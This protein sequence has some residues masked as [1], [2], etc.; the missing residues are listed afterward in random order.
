MPH[1]KKHRRSRKIT[2]KVSPT[3]EK[4]KDLQRDVNN[5]KVQINALTLNIL[6][7]GEEIA[8]K[9][10]QDILLEK[11]IDIIE[12]PKQIINVNTL[13][14]AKGETTIPIDYD[15]E[16]GKKVWS[17]ALSK[18]ESIYTWFSLNGKVN[19]FRIFYYIDVELDKSENSILGNVNLEVRITDSIRNVIKIP[20]LFDVTNQKYQMYSSKV[21][22]IV[23]DVVYVNVSRNSD[24]YN[25]KIYV[26]LI[27]LTS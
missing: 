20:L 3:V 14:M 27:D 26:T 4:I 17:W 19:I 16:E 21:E 9:E 13:A 18:D 2:I 1:N 10:A 6:N 8:P 23:K 22:M 7:Q 12:E 5:I 15:S 25:N 24:T 11:S